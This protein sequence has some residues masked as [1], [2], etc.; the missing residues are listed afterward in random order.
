MPHMVG[1]K[2]PFASEI[3]V[4]KDVGDMDGGLAINGQKGWLEI[5]DYDPCLKDPS[6]CHHGFALSFKLKLDQVFFSL[7]T[8]KRLH[9]IFVF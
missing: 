8:S 4:Q 1:S 5:K 3:F 7:M 2:I 9:T 6:E